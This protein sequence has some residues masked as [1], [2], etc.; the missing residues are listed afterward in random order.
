[1]AAS[2]VAPGSMSA[3]ASAT[4]GV[5][6]ARRTTSLARPALRR[7]GFTGKVTTRQPRPA[8]T[9][10]KPGSSAFASTVAM[11]RTDRAQS[12]SSASVPSMSWP[13]SE[14]GAPRLAPTPTIRDGGR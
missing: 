14:A 5:P 6:T 11:H 7:D 9:A 2:S 3:A 12:P 8:A 1:M 10:C 13:I 4:L